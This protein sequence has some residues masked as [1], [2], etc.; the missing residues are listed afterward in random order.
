MKTVIKAIL[1]LT[2][3]VIGLASCSDDEKDSPKPSNPTPT[4]PSNPLDTAA[5][6]PTK[7]S[8]SIM[9]QSVATDLTYDGSKRLSTAKYSDDDGSSENIFT[10]NAQGQIIKVDKLEDGV[11]VSYFDLIYQ[12][13]R[14][15]TKNTYSKS[16]VTNQFLIES[17]ER[18]IYEGNVLKRINKF[19]FTDTLEV[20]Y[21]Y[22]EFTFDN[23]RNVT[24]KSSYTVTR[25]TMEAKLYSTD[26]YTY[27]NLTSSRPM[28]W[29]IL[30]EFELL[31]NKNLPATY[32]STY[33]DNGV[34][35]VDEVTYNFKNLNNKGFP[36]VLE[37]DT[38]FGKVNSTITYTCD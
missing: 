2:I 9:G 12:N 27:G 17:R 24:K 38:R 23:K 15:I 6:R 33:Y 35:S 18:Y 13:N 26:E 7:F 28:N 16:L 32:K 5:C 1:I 8:A 25:E 11:K 34:P 21:A 37:V 29:M 36:Q 10:Y 19:N 31:N 3:S 20:L 4:T 14:I 30:E 22:D